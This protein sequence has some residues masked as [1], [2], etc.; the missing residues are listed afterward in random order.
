[1]QNSRGWHSTLHL[2]SATR[3]HLWLGFRHLLNTV[4]LSFRL[5]DFRASFCQSLNTD[6]T[7][8]TKHMPHKDRVSST[9]RDFKNSATN[10]TDSIFVF[11]SGR[12]HRGPLPNTFSGHTGAVCG[13]KVSAMR[14]FLF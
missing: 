3:V 4:K 5:S 12:Q 14:C 13:L 10:D 6:D 1:M 11:L 7:V 2:S 8:H 9:E